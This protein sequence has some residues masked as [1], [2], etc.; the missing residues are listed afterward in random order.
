MK[1][2][3]DKGPHIKEHRMPN[4]LSIGSATKRM[5]AAFEAIVDDAA[6]DATLSREERRDISSSFLKGAIPDR[7]IS[8][9]S[10]VHDYV[11][12]KIR[13]AL[14]AVSSNKHT[15]TERDASKLR[16]TELRASLL[17]LFGGHTSGSLG[18]LKSAIARTEVP[19]LND[20]GKSLS[21]ET[22]AN[23][24]FEEVVAAITGYDY[25]AENW[26]TVTGR[27]AAADFARGM[28][29][30]GDTVKQ[31]E[32]EDPTNEPNAL[33]GQQLKALFDDVAGAVSAA[34]KSGGWKSVRSLSHSIQEDG[35]TEYQILVA[36]KKDNSWVTVAYQD[37][38]F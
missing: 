32:D 33:N 28:V 12:P 27:R 21:F 20:Y 3:V 13:R 23:K 17:S 8:V 31:G 24:T 26:Q 4:S 9:E 37:F 14:F 34:L 1:A 38:P 25:S 6:K 2:H 16:V 29:Q 22:F 11:E 18:A 10:A 7:R 15:V 35:D 5:T 30:V 36:Q 19:Q